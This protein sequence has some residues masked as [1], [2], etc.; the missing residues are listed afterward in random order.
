MVL[1]HIPDG[2]APFHARRR[3]WI[4]VNAQCGT[5]VNAVRLDIRLARDGACLFGASGCS[6]RLAGTA[7]ASCVLGCFPATCVWGQ[8]RAGCG[9]S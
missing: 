8:A 2:Y 9:Y 5:T 3:S 1:V 6:V 4:L 7:C